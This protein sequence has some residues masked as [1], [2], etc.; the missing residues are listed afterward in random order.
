MHF[1]P[2]DGNQSPGHLV[3][4]GMNRRSVLRYSVPIIAAMSV[5][6]ACGSGDSATPAKIRIGA[7]PS[8][9]NDGKLAA[10]SE[11]AAG[12][13]MIAP[14]LYPQV[15]TV[16][17]LA[18]GLS[19]PGGKF[20]AWRFP[21]KPEPVSQERKDALAQAFGLTGSWKAIPADQGGGET[22]A[23]T[24][25]GATLF[26]GADAMQ[27]WWY[28]PDWTRFP[29][30][31]GCAEPGVAVSDPV[32]ADRSDATVESGS[33]STTGATADTTEVT[34]IERCAVPA[35]PEGVPT[36]DEAKAR[37]IALLDDLGYDVDDFS[38]E[39][40]GDQWGSWTTSW[41]LLDGQ[42]AQ[43]AVYVSYGAEGM[44]TG[45]GGFLA[46]PEKA[47]EYELVDLDVAVKR[48]NDQ[49]GTWF[50]AYGGPNVRTAAVD[51]G[52]VSA[53]AADGAAGSGA[54]S[55][56]GSADATEPAPPDA[57]VEPTGDTGELTEP[58]TVPGEL[59]DPVETTIVTTTVPVEEV[60]VTLTKVRVELT[61][62]WDTDGTIWLLPSY[63]FST[64]DQGEYS[65][66]A[67]ADEYIEFAQPD[68]V[69]MP[70]EIEPAPG[71]VADDGTAITVEAPT[72]TEATKEN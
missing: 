21:A 9:A 35:P 49:S 48:L 17:E 60:T 40:A 37:T 54:S 41:L 13:R 52:A 29:A 26:I 25:G 56:G 61:Q 2:T 20:R 38:V 14:G 32:P 30:Q 39:A 50:G 43:L 71:P 27:N 1:S 19:K 64:K 6:A 33:G 59:V 53:V 31:V 44:I 36:A 45:A 62:V 4:G 65:V 18:D 42:R 28:S 16:F 46:Q 68:V 67:L 24:A 11:A 69:P 63:V 5:L 10:S 55:S 51:T 34:K 47:D 70:A 12:D 58:S 22:L 15:R 66:L 8:G 23:P 7:A 57:T 72:V 3:T